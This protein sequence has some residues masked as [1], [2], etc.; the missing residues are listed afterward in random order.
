MKKKTAMECLSLALAGALFAGVAWQSLSSPTPIKAESEVTDLIN[1]DFETGNA[2]GWNIID[3]GNGGIGDG[4]FYAS[5][6]T[7]WTGRSFH[8]NGNYFFDGFVNEGWTGTVTSNDFV[9]RGEG[10]ISALLGGMKDKAEVYLQIYDVTLAKTVAKLS[11]DGFS[12]PG[13]AENLILNY[14]H[15]PD[16]IGHTLRIVIVDNATSGFGAVV[17]DDIHASLTWAEVKTQIEAERSE[18]ATDEVSDGAAFY[19]DANRF[20]AATAV[21]NCSFESGD[22]YGWSIA[23]GDINRGTS[24]SSDTTFWAEGVPFNQTGTCFFDPWTSGIGED[25]TYHIYSAAFTLGG[26]GWVS[27]KMAGRTAKCHVRLANGTEIASVSNEANFVDNLRVSAGGR[28]GTLVRNYL[29]LS[30]YLND[31]LFFDFEDYGTSGW[32][33]VFFDDV[34]GYYAD[35]PATSGADT[36]N[37]SGTI[38]GESFNDT[39]VA[40]NWLYPANASS[41][42]AAA[43]SYLKAFKLY[44]KA[45]GGSICGLLSDA[46][47]TLLSDYDAINDSAVKAIVDASVD[48]M[49]AGVTTTVGETVAYLKSKK[50]GNEQP[51]PAVGKEESDAEIFGLVSLG[52]AAITGLTVF[53]TLRKRHR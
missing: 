36:I 24:I 18:Y 43:N 45:N 34:I 25:Q 7:Y 16:S 14:A 19:N 26:S 44:R 9:L 48:V 49:N 11:N 39:N 28:T 42:G 22:A 27:W 38:N 52:F 2:T 10:Y 12:D 29:D 1:G 40:V 51:L 5:S 41:T 20:P 23:H 30:G 53:L 47:S 21:P 37:Q 46:S 50:A 3:G 13:R 33:I 15:L 6:D 31:T 32:G 17:A 35:V 8:A 4:V